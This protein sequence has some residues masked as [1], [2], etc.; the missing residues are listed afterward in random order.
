M[1]NTTLSQ[2]GDTALD[3]PG[4]LAYTIL[5]TM[6]A[7]V[8]GV[9][10]GVTAIALVTVGSITHPLWLFLI[11]LLL[12]G[13]VVAMCMILIVGTFVALVVV[14]PEQPRSPLY[15][16]RVNLWMYG[17]GSAARL[18]NL[19]AFSFSVL[20]IVR[21]GKKTII[22]CSMLQSSLP[23]SGLFLLL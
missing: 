7:L 15:L 3:S 11:N 19:A 14:T 23:S 13:L 16:C 4:F 9:V 5:L 1:N 8:A 21:F 20:A 10:M 12:A 2:K 18:L 17:M 22:A 6:I